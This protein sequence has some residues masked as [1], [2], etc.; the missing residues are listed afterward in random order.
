MNNLI[1]NWTKDL[2]R[3]LIKEDMQM[4]DKFM[5][6]CSTSYVM[7]KEIKKV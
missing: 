6:S 3:H 7:K 5:E 4:T 2:K 1:Q